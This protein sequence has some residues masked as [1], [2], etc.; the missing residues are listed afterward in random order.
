[1]QKPAGKINIQ[2]LEPLIQ[3]LTKLNPSALKVKK[4]M[5]EQGIPFSEDPIQQLSTVLTF[6]NHTS[7]K[8]L[9]D[10]GVDL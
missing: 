3:E 5:L 2:S 7:A 6:M 4:M 1:M 8:V 10:D 9:E